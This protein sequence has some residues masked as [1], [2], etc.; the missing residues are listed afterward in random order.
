MSALCYYYGYCY[1]GGAIVVLPAGSIYIDGS[2]CSNNTCQGNG[3]CA[4]VTGEL[5]LYNNLIISGNRA[6]LNSAGIYTDFGATIILY[7][8]Y[9]YRKHST[10]VRWSFFGPYIPT[11]IRYYYNYKQ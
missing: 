9:H 2:T 10:T 1:A 4:H 6:T 7:R 8:L 3:G 11:A 5:F